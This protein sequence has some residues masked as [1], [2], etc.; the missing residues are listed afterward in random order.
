MQVS[1]QRKQ[2]YLTRGGSRI[3]FR[4]G[5]TRLLLYFNSNKPHSFFFCRMPVVLENN[6]SSQGGRGGAYPLHPPPRSGPAYGIL[7]YQ[8]L[9][10]VGKLNFHITGP[11]RKKRN[12][13]FGERKS[14][15]AFSFR[16][17]YMAG[18]RSRFPKH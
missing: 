17:G 15:P 18:N 6:R 2:R 10:C 9:L 3:F 8:I 16:C 1:S 7:F 14:R 13:T 12:N 11:D 4:R 5:C